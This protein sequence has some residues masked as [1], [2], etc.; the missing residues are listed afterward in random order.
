MHSQNDPHEI[1]LPARQA[2][3]ARFGKLADP[4]GLLDERA[5]ERRAELLR[6]AYFVDLSRRSAQSRAAKKRRLAGKPD[7]EI[8]GEEGH[9][10][11]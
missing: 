2:F 5:R 11:G 3:M 1:T 4:D 10:C 6:R 8:A 7:S 9:H